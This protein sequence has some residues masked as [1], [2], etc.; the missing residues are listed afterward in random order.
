MSKTLSI[1]NQPMY[2]ERQYGESHLPLIYSL[3]TRGNITA[4]KDKTPLFE[5]IE[6]NNSVRSQS[7][8][9]AKSTGTVAV[10]NIKSP[11][12]KYD[13]F[14]GPMGTQTMIRKLT[15]WENDPNIKGVVFD[16][17]SGGGQAYGTP[18]LYDIIKN[19]KKPTES[20]TNGFMCSAAYYGFAGSDQ[21]TANS[22]AEHIG[23]IGAYAQILDVRGIIEKEG[24]K[25]HT[26][27]ATKSTEKNKEFREVLEGDYDTYIS[28]SLDP[29]VDEFIEDMKSVRPQLS[30]QVFEGGTFNAEKSLEYG[31]IDRVGTLQD[32]INSVF[33]RSEEELKTNNTTM[34]KPK[35]YPNLESVLGLESPLAS[36][37]QGSYLNEDQKQAIE[38]HLSDDSHTTELKNLKEELAASKLEVD[39]KNE[40]IAKLAELAGVETAKD[41]SEEDLQTAFES[42][43]KE[44]KA[45]PG[46]THTA[47]KTNT[48]GDLDKHPYI[49]FNSSIYKP[50]QKN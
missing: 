3:L 12:V 10:M 34:S 38:D 14:C 16:I 49:D 27:Y 42:K 36:N 17:D 24:G 22:R 18:L 5:L 35:S 4:S 47:G 45:A 8:Q 23:S 46:E 6:M 37:D 11:I 21:I 25:V 2:I 48:T 15:E 44:L 40:S 32:A 41:A 7:G 50:F 33:E 1:L 30:E 28:Q 19:Y 20:Y 26:M 29:L 13:Q 43:I 31:L 9:P 39:S